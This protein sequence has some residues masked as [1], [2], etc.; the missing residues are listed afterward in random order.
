[1]PGSS[2][3]RF[4]LRRSCS[5][6]SW[7]SR[8]FWARRTSLRSLLP[9]SVPDK[10]EST[11]VLNRII[12]PYIGF[13]SISALAMGVLNSFGRFGASAFAP[14]LL[15]L[16]VIALS[17]FSDFFP[18]PAI[19]LSVGVVIGGVLQILIQ[20]PSLLR[21]G[22]RFRWFWDLA[23][24]GVRRV[25]ALIGPRLFGIGIVQIDVLVGTQFASHMIEGSAASIGLA[26]RVMELVLGGYAIALSTA[27]LPLLARQ[28]AANRMED[29]KGTL[30]FATR[31]IL[32]ITLPA[33]VGLIL[34]RVPIIEVLFEGGEFD[35]Q[36]TALTAWALLFFAVG[37]S[38][39]SMIKVIV[40]AFYALHDTWTP[41]VI[42][43]FSLLV[44]IALQF[45]FLSMAQKWRASAGNVTGGVLRCDRFDDCLPAALRHSGPP[46]RRTIVREVPAGLERDGRGDLCVYPNTGRLCR[47]P[48][49]SEH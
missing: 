10:L 19:A 48:G 39:F 49:H 24:P 47:Q 21:T 23:H 3:T 4:S 43:F 1:M 33:T 45:P 2:S 34:L 18:N 32:F 12:F 26:D 20:I 37:L 35:A 8:A 25:A 38:A 7:S 14:V 9:D 17:F 31:L 15:N 6:R 40:Q 22:W 44:N 46:L 11:T 13:V 16:S 28:A 36:S 5:C 29:M 30:S 27:V 42:G 41:V